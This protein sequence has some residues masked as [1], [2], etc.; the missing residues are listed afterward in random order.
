MKYPAALSCFPSTLNSI[1]PR[2]LSSRSSGYE[3]QKTE[4]VLASQREVVLSVL[5]ASHSRGASPRPDL[6][7]DGKG[8][9]VI[10]EYV[11]LIDGELTLESIA[12]RGSRLVITIP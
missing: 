11:R 1:S 9:S 3:F 5:A 2:A 7:A 12:G 10:K 8:P 6:E 4:N